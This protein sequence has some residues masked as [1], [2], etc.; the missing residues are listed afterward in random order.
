MKRSNTSLLLAGL[1]AYA[2]YKYSKMNQQDKDK[3]VR[4]L[5]EKGRNMLSGLNPLRRQNVGTHTP[6][7]AARP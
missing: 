4:D 1:A 3:L 7:M 6:S 2:Y 5:K